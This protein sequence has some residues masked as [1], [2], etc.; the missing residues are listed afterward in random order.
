M[1]TYKHF[2]TQ[3][4]TSTPLPVGFVLLYQLYC[5]VNAKLFVND[6]DIK[7][8]TKQEKVKQRLFYRDGLF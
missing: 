3:R 8:N 4:V 1:P 2:N 5:M 7:Y 6:L